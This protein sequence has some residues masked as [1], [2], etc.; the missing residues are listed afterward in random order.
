MQVLYN[1]HLGNIVLVKFY[2]KRAET[3]N[4]G[5]ARKA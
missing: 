5:T 2:S 4:F 3:N 1:E